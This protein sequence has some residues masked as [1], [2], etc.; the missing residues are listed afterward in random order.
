M[1]VPDDAGRVLLPLARGAIAERLGLRAPDVERADWLDEPG[2]SFVTLTIGDRLRG[3][4]GTILAHRPLGD[5]VVAN[6]RHAA[7][8]DSRFAPLR[9]DEFGAVTLEVSVLTAPDPVRFTSRDDLLARLR[10]GTDGLIVRAVGRRAT[11]LPQVWEKLPD[12]GRFVEQLL[13]KAGLPES[14]W[15]PDELVVERYGVRAW[16]EPDGYESKGRG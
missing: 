1:S 10:P 6:A 7:F 8:D 5:D 11:F 15:E 3:C 12:P 13:R 4:I 2:A 16:S 14:W 9:A